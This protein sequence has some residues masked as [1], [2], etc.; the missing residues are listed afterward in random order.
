MDIQSVNR[1]GK[2]VFRTYGSYINSLKMKIKAEVL[3]WGH[4]ISSYC[5]QT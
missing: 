2:F 3:Y 4:S 5:V 1:L